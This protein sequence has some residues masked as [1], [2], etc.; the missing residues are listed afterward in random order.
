M[1]TITLVCCFW[2]NQDQN[3]KTVYLLMERPYSTLD[4]LNLFYHK[5]RNPLEYKG[6]LSAINTPSPNK[7]DIS[8]GIR[9]SFC[10]M[11]TSAVIF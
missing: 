6:G 10:L 2:G 9:P 3:N 1:E 4:T 5:L 8:T 7:N 11:P